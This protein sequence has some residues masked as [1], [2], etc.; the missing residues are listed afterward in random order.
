MP[1]AM[2][3]ALVNWG[4]SQAMATFVVNFALS[5]VVN[6]I[7]SPS[8]KEPER[9]KDP[10]VDQ[11][12]NPDTA[13]KL[14][15]IYGK[16]RVRG[17]IIMAELSEDNNTM[18]Y[19][20]ALGEGAINS[21]GLARYEGNEL[22]L[23][24]DINIGLR[25][26]TAATD[27]DGV[28][29]PYIVGNLRLRAYPD[30][31]AC[32]EMESF[33]SA[34][35]SKTRTM[36]NTPYIYV[37]LDYDREEGVTGLGDLSFDVEGKK[38][39][40]LTSGS[41]STTRTYSTNPAEIIVDYMTDNV[42]GLSLADT[43]LDLFSFQ[44]MK[45]FCDQLITY[46]DTNGDSQTA[47]RYTC[48][49][50]INTNTSTNSNLSNLMIAYQT[51]LSYNQGKFAVTVD[52]AK[53]ATKQLDSNDF[54]GGISLTDAGFDDLIN[55]LTLRYRS[56]KNNYK[57]DQVVLESPS[58][59]KNQNEPLLERTVELPFTSNSVEAERA[60]SIIMNQ[61]RSSLGVKFRVSIEHIDLQCG[62]IIG[63]TDETTGFQ[64][65]LFRV[66]SIMEINEN[67]TTL[68]VTAVEYEAA[69]YTDLTLA[70]REDAVDTN[71]LS[72][73]KI[74]VVS[75]ISA[76]DTLQ[77]LPAIYVSWNAADTGFVDHYELRY[78]K[79]TDTVYQTKTM[80]STNYTLT[81]LESN[82]TYNV[83]VRSF[84]SLGRSSEW[85]DTTETTLN[86]NPASPTNMTA[87]EEIFNTNQ[88][89]GIRSK[90]TL[91]WDSVPESG[92]TFNSLTHIIYKRLASET[93][94]EFVGTTTN[95]SFIFEDLKPD[96][97]DF[98]VEPKSLIGFIGT[99]TVVSNI[100]VV[101]LTA[102][103]A[104]VTGFQ[105]NPNGDNALLTWDKSEEL[106]VLFG[107]TVQIRYNPN[108]DVSATWETS[109]ILVGS[110]SGT[111]TSKTVP[112]VRGTYFIKFVDSG[113]RES[114]TAPLITN[115]FEPTNFN[116]VAITDEADN[117]FAGT[118]TDMTYTSAT[119]TITTGVGVTSGTYTFE[120][121]IDLGSVQTVR[122]TPEYQATAFTRGSSFCDITSGLC[123]IST[124]C[125]A[126]PKSSIKYE[127]RT[128]DNDPAGTPVWS[129]W[130][131]LLTGNYRNRAFEF[132]VVASVDTDNDAISFTSLGINLDIKDKRQIGSAT[133]SAAADTTVTFA[134]SGFFAGLLGT[135]L[136]KI[137]VNI[138]GGSSGDNVVI[139]N[140]SATTFDFSVYNA[141]SRVVRDIDW[142]AIGQ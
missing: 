115:T 42:S 105:I 35:A 70:E 100:N 18:A 118:L 86:R 101:G 5:V 82:T 109:Q 114:E 16:N 9:Q 133:S 104:D 96:V 55:K 135:T 40:T 88:A 37:E 34:W 113:G 36:P 19:I 122:I 131:P 137:G 127:I 120:D 24:G 117:N 12:V 80:S 95:T 90:L 98:K 139:S 41:L 6:K 66:M 138:I 33:S 69:N 8:P 111:T 54:L 50:T 74:S 22:T 140:R 62:D 58:S 27:I 110:L 129:D 10:G 103:P 49:G 119:N 56:V 2:V 15:I 31:G 67:L 7:F 52:K 46:T 39:R 57:D 132:R 107:G 43:D 124:F 92:S 44:E 85:V 142:Q 75:N 1:Q 14:P 23:D 28:S 141:G 29:Q 38:I 130:A 134:D 128:T 60:G 63:I 47:K 11:R 68:E 76:E 97:Y 91:D 59:V 30:G 48:N 78:K 99:A 21:V 94:W 136:P 25:S 123:T 72:P 32:S 126:A 51:A 61:S 125:E 65:E 13:N 106:D 73:N 17:T 79:S 64:G 93:E 121:Y 84:S 89:A 3:A 116:I 81:G 20:I 112:L 4:L 77:D 53:T 26:V 108:I 102:A 45:D 71:L 83:G 87:V